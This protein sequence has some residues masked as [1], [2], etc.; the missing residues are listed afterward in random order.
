MSLN[1]VTSG[2]GQ[3]T[4]QATN[5]V[6]STTKPATDTVQN[7]TK[8]VTDT[9]T[10]TT[11]SALPGAF[12]KDEPPT[13]ERNNVTIPS[14]SAIWTNF[15][16]WLKGLIP[17]GIDI[18]E[19]AVRRFVTWL[20]PPERQAA[21]YRTAIE[22]PIAATFLAAQLL[23]VGIPLVLFIAGTLIFAAVAMIVWVVLSLLILGPIVLVASLLGV[24]LWGWGWF[25]FGLVRWIDRLFL[26]GVM[27]RFWIANVQRE[28]EEEEAREKEKEEQ[29]KAKDGAGEA[30]RDTESDVKK[31]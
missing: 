14:W 11:N 31:E 24:S 2:L 23:C 3:A 12:P 26:G 7:T 19:A 16:T 8:P 27:E 20:I 28:K 22:H 4:N 5:T 6:S 30:N 1:T 13:N 18:F 29:E 25:V 10:S 21:M 9:V 15:I 17:R